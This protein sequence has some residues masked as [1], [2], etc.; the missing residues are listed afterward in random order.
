[1]VIINVL[2][3]AYLV[4]AT[5]LL[6]TMHLIRLAYWRRGARSAQSPGL[7]FAQVAVLW[8]IL[9][10]VLLWVYLERLLKGNSNG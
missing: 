5:V 8:P 2:L 6:L 9:M 7:I 10:V 3:V 1:M 4:V